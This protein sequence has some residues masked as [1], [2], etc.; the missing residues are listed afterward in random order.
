MRGAPRKI[1]LER[2]EKTSLLSLRALSGRFSANSASQA[3]DSRFVGLKVPEFYF[4]G[5]NTSMCFLVV[6]MA[7]CVKGNVKV[8]PSYHAFHWSR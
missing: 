5:S 7:F 2:R 3:L 4:P 1:R 8:V 6:S